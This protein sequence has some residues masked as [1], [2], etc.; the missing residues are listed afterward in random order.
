[1]SPLASEI[2]AVLERT[3]KQFSEIADVHLDVPWREFLQTWGEVRAA[4]I[5]KRDD[6]GAYYI[7]AAKQE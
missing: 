7:D 3:P 1:M 6:D 2:T 4:D 5:L